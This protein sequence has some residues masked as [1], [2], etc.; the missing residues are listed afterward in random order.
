MS[1]R[2]CQIRPVAHSSA[3]DG[4]GAHTSPCLSS[5]FL[6]ENSVV[7]WGQV[8]PNGT[9]INDGEKPQV[10][11]DLVIVASMVAT[12]LLDFCGFQQVATMATMNPKRLRK[13]PLFQTI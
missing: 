2:P 4:M 1:S 8:K 7:P 5:Q 6:I 12:K 13:T 3:V 9:V 11:R 10:I